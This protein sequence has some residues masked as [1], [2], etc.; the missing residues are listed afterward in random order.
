[1]EK[2]RTVRENSQVVVKELRE[3]SQKLEGATADLEALETRAAS[4]TQERQAHEALLADLQPR[5][6]LAKKH[7]ARSKAELDLLEKKR[8]DYETMRREE[9]SLEGRRSAAESRLADLATEHASLAKERDS[10]LAMRNALPYPPLQ[11]ESLAALQERMAALQAR[12]RDTLSKRKVLEQQAISADRSLKE[13]GAEAAMLDALSQQQTEK[14]AA[15][16]TAQERLLAESSLASRRTALQAER[17]QSQRGHL[18][19]RARPPAGGAHSPRRGG[20]ETLFAQR[21]PLRS[22]D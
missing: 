1:M 10:L 19:A 6:E 22:R 13:A 3:R 14:R 9:V 20:E 17:E 11:E 18:R 21:R 5:L 15:L 4:L 12:M 2:Y 16:A 8:R 7:L